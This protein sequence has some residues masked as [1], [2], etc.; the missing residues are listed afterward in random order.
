[1]V[2]KT[3]ISLYIILGLIILAVIILF[4]W[5]K[6]IYISD[7]H[8]YIGY[9]INIFILLIFFSGI[10]KIFLELKRYQNEEN[11]ILKF[12]L[13]YKNNVE[14]KLLGVDKE[15]LIAQRYEIVKKLFEEGFKPDIKILSGFLLSNE[16]NRKTYLKYINNILILTGVFGTVIS[17]IISL[18][19][20]SNF[21]KLTD[22][23]SMSIIIFG[24]STALNTTFTAILCFFIYNYFLLKLNQVQKNIS[25]QIEKITY[26][27]IF[28]EFET[29]KE[30]I[31][32]NFDKHLNEIK[33]VIEKFNE[34]QEG[35]KEYALK[36]SKLINLNYET[37]RKL[38]ADLKN[39]Q[40]ILKEGFRLK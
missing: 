24:M 36:F 5:L 39:I 23:K 18:L 9:V 34:T 29:T 16:E 40:E 20:A 21:I 38:E 1:M 4:P 32:I 6:K 10:V 11:S 25:L 27:H 8:S 30:K 15:S 35:L 33:N 12:S 7:V 31:I 2:K 14:E 22:E 37:F 13:N 19:G 28:P 26:F 17:L 3:L